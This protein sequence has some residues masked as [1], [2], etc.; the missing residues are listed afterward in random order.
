MDRIEDS[1]VRCDKCG[2]ELRVNFAV[3][4]RSGWP[5]CCGW[6]MRLMTTKAD[7]AAAADGIFAGV[8]EQLAD[9]DSQPTLEGAS[10]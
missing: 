8:R 1:R 4:L 7:I 5:K 9:L 6:T 3:C 10:S 2:C